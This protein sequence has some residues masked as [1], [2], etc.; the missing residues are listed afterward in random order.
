MS[1]D[2]TKQQFLT[3]LRDATWTFKKLSSDVPRA[4]VHSDSGECPYVYATRN[5][6]RASIVDGSRDITLDV[7]HAADGDYG[8]SP[9]LRREVM[10]ACNLS[11]PFK[12]RR[13]V[14]AVETE[15]GDE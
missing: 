13:L 2:L 14:D 3:S 9:F 12:A 1:S 4:I 8:H 15:A 11:L 7:I 5:C 6:R 10:Q